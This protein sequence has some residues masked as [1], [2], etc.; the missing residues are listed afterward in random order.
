MQN[1]LCAIMAQI[2]SI[3]GLVSAVIISGSLTEKM[4]LYTGFLQ[5][6]AGLSVG[7]CGLAAGFAIGVVGDAGGEYSCKDKKK[8]GGG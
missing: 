1:T 5:L 4:A 7:L 3:Y 2:L 8:G 6:G